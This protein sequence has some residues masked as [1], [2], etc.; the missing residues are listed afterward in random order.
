MR[1]LLPILLSILALP[2]NA[3]VQDLQRDFR[4]RIEAAY[5]QPDPGARAAALENLFYRQGLDKS[6]DALLDRT[7]QQL[8]K[9]AHGQIRFTALPGDM[10]PVH[11]LNGYEYRP[12]L[13]PLGQVVLTA[14]GAPPGNATYILYGKHPEQDRFMFPAT[15]RKAINP[16]APEDKLLQILAVGIGNPPV[17]FSGWCDITLSNGATQRVTLRDNGAGN[18][19]RMLRGQKIDT[20]ELRRE[21]GDGSLS[22]RLLE[23]QKQIF[24]QRIDDSAGLIRYRAP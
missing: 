15:V 20:C 22:L 3:G 19:S 4:E 14:S 23:G 13:A 10:D 21:G 18:Q 7:V 16:G 12:N 2:A 5:R 17:A 9:S 8:L 11:V 1:T 6:T 24:L